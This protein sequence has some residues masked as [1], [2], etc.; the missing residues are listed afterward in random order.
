MAQV[1]INVLAVVVAAVANMI[2][3]SIW[4][5]PGVFGKTWMSLAGVQPGNMKGGAG[6]A[7]AGSFVVALI[8][9]YVL[10]HFVGYTQASTLGQGIQLGFWVW[11]GFVATTSSGDYIFGG[12]PRPLYV[13]NNGYHLVTLLVNGALLAVWR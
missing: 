4:Y 2:I 13:I 8:L 11:L 6:P 9:A 5:S 3:G 12:R 7:Y 1:H 10:A